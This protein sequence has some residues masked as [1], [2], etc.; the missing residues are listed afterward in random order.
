MP[1]THIT[2]DIFHIEQRLVHV[3]SLLSGQR[4]DNHDKSCLH[5]DHKE[6]ENHTLY[7][8]IFSH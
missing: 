1:V 7:E 3:E 4:G 5:L 6:C 8:N 2:D